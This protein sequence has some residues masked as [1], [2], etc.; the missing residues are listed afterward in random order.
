MTLGQEF[1]AFATLLKE[2]VRLIKKT[3]DLLLEINLGATAIGIGVNT[4]WL[5]SAS[6]PEFKSIDGI[7]THWCRGLC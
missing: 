5:C 4:T 2:D 7:K 6:E 3:R 1:H